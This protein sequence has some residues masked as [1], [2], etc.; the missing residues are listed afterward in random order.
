MVYGIY[1]GRSPGKVARRRLKA[2]VFPTEFAFT[3]TVG[4][5]DWRES[6][7]ATGGHSLA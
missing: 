1:V 2:D 4:R 3:A 5:G 6:P 7:T